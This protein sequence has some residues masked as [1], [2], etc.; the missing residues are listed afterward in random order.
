MCRKSLSALC[1]F[2]S[3]IFHC[4]NVNLWMHEAEKVRESKGK[5]LSDWESVIP[6][7]GGYEKILASYA[8]GIHSLCILTNLKLSTFRNP[9]RNWQCAAFIINLI[10][11]FSFCLVNLK[12]STALWAPTDSIGFSKWLYS[13]V[14]KLKPLPHH[15]SH[16]VYV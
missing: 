15:Y 13:A 5:W 7:A 16:C 1:N 6:S 4:A 8:V 9:S 11:T 10:F 12:Y 14:V 3:W 2:S